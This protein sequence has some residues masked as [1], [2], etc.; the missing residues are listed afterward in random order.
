MSFLQGQFGAH[1][2]RVLLENEK[3][4][5]ENT[6]AAYG[7][8]QNEYKGYCEVIYSHEPYPYTIT[9]E[10]V[11]GFMYY[12]AYRAHFNVKKRNSNREQIHLNFD[13]ADFNMVMAK[14]QCQE[15]G[16][17][18]APTL[19]QVEAGARTSHG[20]EL[21]GISSFK[22]YWAAILEL[23]QHQV[24]YNANNLLKC[25]L[26]S[27]RMK[28][29]R[30]QV[31]TRKA[32]VAKALHK[33]KVSKDINPFLMIE[34]LD[35]MEKAMFYASNNSRTN[36]MAGLRNR[37]TL[38]CTLQQVTR[39]ESLFKCELSDLID[40]VYQSRREPH[41]YHVLVMQVHTGK[42]NKGKTVYGRSIRHRRAHRC[43][44]GALALYLM[45]RFDL[46]KE[47]EEMDFTENSKWF[48]IKLLV[49][50]TVKNNMVAVKDTYYADAIKKSAKSIG[51]DPSHFI[52]FG[53]D[54]QPAV[55][56]AEE[57]P[58]PEIKILGNWNMDVFDERY[59]S[60]MPFRAMRVSAGFDLD[61][62]CHI[63]ARTMV[64][65]PESLKC[66]VFPGLAVAEER[67]RTHEQESASAPASR[68]A[69]AKKTAA[70]FIRLMKNL[71]TVVLQDAAVL[72]HS[73]RQHVVFNLPVFK[74]SQFLSFQRQVVAAVA[75]AERSDPGERT[76]STVLP[77]LNQR[78]DAFQSMT[79]AGFA[80]VNAKQDANMSTL[81]NMVSPM[82]RFLQHVTNF[83]YNPNQ[84]MGL[85][86]PP[87]QISPHTAPPE[88]STRT[89][90][91][92]S[93]TPGIAAMAGGGYEPSSTYDSVSAIYNEWYGIPP[94]S[95]PEGGILAQENTHKSA[96]RSSW[97]S[98]VKKRFSRI[99]LIVGIVESIKEEMENVSREIILEV[100]NQEFDDK[101]K[102]LYKF[103]VYINKGNGRALI[104]E[105]IQQR[106]TGMTHV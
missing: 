25:Q 44:M 26:E 34:K 29:L 78:F 63:N 11:F 9:E 105:K 3:N 62:G 38:L 8:K 64:F 10:K 91:G 12:Q 92:T 41:P 82:A 98:G 14:T 89:S 77:A 100:F 43:A 36:G 101:K 102:S 67:L 71:Q 46:S 66:Q 15:R 70:A 39:G 72:I 57:L 52:H 28:A 69:T 16:N 32:R 1:A 48:D 65:P 50:R 96:W 37:F 60:H 76:L 27:L 97:D 17:S 81:V 90:Q 23:H 85:V 75:A 53:R 87:Q 58:A 35:D 30:N 55:L 68:S 95:G 73:G 93:V 47:L 21:L 45:L 51:A 56:E 40:F 74:S 86:L 24:A 22:Q 104:V 99:K 4:R 13:K 19:A 103:E 2:Q 54:V 79:S 84:V 33:E 49:D 80:A 59:S 94:H 20:Q 42:T 88:T 7:P 83:R 18:N 31:A 61:R 6:K 5:P 106:A